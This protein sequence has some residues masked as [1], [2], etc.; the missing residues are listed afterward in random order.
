MTINLDTEIEELAG[1]D[2]IEAVTT[3][4]NRVSGEIVLAEIGVRLRTDLT[5]NA[6]IGLGETQYLT[7]LVG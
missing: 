5:E 3:S 6:G 2:V 7:K 1:G 4:D